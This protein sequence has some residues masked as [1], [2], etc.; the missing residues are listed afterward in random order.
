[1]NLHR[2][3]GY[4]TPCSPIAYQIV[5]VTIGLL[6]FCFSDPDMQKITKNISSCPVCKALVRNP[7][8]FLP[9]EIE[10]QTFLKAWS[11]DLY[12]LL[13]QFGCHHVR[14]SNVI[15]SSLLKH[16]SRRWS[17]SIN[18]LILHSLCKPNSRIA[19]SYL[20][21]QKQH[22]NGYYLHLLFFIQRNWKRNKDL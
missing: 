21:F 19:A 13:C 20:K 12:I 15:N 5:C 11:D 14:I 8:D 3:Y 10:G 6:S 17:I 7:H 4:L 22:P 9:F 18:H 2:Y 16:L 1:M